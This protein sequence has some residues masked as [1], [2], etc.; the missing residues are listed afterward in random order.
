[1]TDELAAGD[2]LALRNA[3]AFDWGPRDRE[4]F[5][6]AW[7]EVVACLAP[8]GTLIVALRDHLRAGQWCAVAGWCPEATSESVAGVP[9]RG[10]PP[11]GR[12]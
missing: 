4:F 11:P 3:A 10:N 9:S 2:E 7:P 1:M 12:C 6:S 5:S 8:G